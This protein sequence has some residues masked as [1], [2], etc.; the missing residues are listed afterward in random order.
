MALTKIGTDGVK[1]DAVTSGKI[2]ANAVG[3]SEIADTAVTLAK[4]EHGTSSNDG[5]FLRANN[6]ADPSFEPVS[7]VGG[8]TGVAFNDDVKARFGTGNDLEIYHDGSNSYI[9][10]GGTGDLV[11]NSNSTISLNPNGGGH[12]GARV[13]TGGAVELYHN[14]VKK[15]TTTADGVCF[16]S[17]TAAAN[18]LD[19]YE[20]GTWTPTVAGWDT[21]TPY[22]GSSY[23]VAWYT[24]IGNLV[25]VGWKLYIQN[26]TTVSTSDYIRFE[27]LPFAQ[28]STHA[29]PVSAPI[30][31]DIPEFGFSGT[32]VSY[33]A[34]G[35]TTIYTYKHLNSTS[36][37]TSINA[38]ANRSNVWT[39]GSAT[40]LTN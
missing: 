33:M 34:S 7:S 39:M 31:F 24:K 28:K 38:T 37:I 22:T 2:P 21:Y 27:G 30:R 16:N 23:N 8:A 35:E 19:D 11:V 13:I 36:S 25:H 17:D 3:S 29:G 20:E 10:E 15:L 26:L 32:Q 6:G 9:K 5:K 4:L 40:Y 18:A 12:Y 14:N 1:D